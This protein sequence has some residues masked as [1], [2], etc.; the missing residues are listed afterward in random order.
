MSGFLL[1]TN[2]VSEARKGSRCN[3][4][5]RRWMESAKRS[6][7]VFL[8]VISLAEIKMGITRLHG[9]DPKQAAALEQWRVFLE[10]SY[11]QAGRLLSIDASIA[12]AWG[13]LQGIRPIAQMDCF[14][15]A[16]AVVWQI[17]IVTRDTADFEGLPV[18]VINPF[19][20]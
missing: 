18:S 15:A 13:R 6:G 4:N 19:D 17:S 3:A 16:T 5:V 2:I 8:S 11:G 9:R 12:A 1:D 14:L 7:N 20:G 10:K